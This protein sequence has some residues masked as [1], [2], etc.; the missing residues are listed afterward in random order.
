MRRRH[1]LLGLRQ[2]A[3]GGHDRHRGGEAGNAQR[4]GDG[5]N[6]LTHVLESPRLG[7]HFEIGSAVPVRRTEMNE[8]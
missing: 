6:E 4:G 8:Q 7:G 2:R 3:I 1:L 5:T